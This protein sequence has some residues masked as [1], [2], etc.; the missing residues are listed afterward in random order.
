MGNINNQIM[1]YGYGHQ[2]QMQGQGHYQ[3]GYQQ[4][5]YQ[6]QGYQQQGYHQQGYQMQG[7]YQQGYGQPQGYSGYQNHNWQGY[8]MKPM[9]FDKHNIDT[10]GLQLFQK[11]DYD[12]SGSLNIM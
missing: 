9:P 7:H 3:Q 6:Q 1:N 8:Q 12:R 2:N 4:Q 11:H 5:G 10:M